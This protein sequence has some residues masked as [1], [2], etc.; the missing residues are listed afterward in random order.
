ME[1]LPPSLCLGFYYDCFSV[2]IRFDFLSFSEGSLQ[3]V[4][5][6]FAQKFSDFR[7]I[8]Q[9]LPQEDSNCVSRI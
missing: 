5:R 8:R 6:D 9:H 3:T 2:K 1:M 7:Q 4:Q